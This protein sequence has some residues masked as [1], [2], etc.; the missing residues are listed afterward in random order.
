MSHIPANRFKK[1]LHGKSISIYT[2]NNNNGVSLQVTNYGARIVS[3]YVPDRNGVPQDIVLGYDCIEDYLKTKNS[4][5]GATVGR[6]ANRIAN[7][8]FTLNN[9]IY[10]LNANDTTHCLHGGAGGFHN[11]VWD[12]HQISDTALELTY[13]SP[14]GEE[15]FPGT[16]SVKV[17]YSI[18][19]NSEVSIT[20]FATTDKTTVVNLTHHSYFNLQDAGKTSIEDHQLEI[21]ASNYTPVN[22]SL[23]PRGPIETVSDTP[24]DFRIATK[25]GKRI[26][27][28]NEQL[29]IG[30]GYD[31]NYVLYGKDLRK[32]ATVKEP[33]SGRVMEIVTTEP[34]I[35]FYSGNLIH[36]DILGKNKTLYGNRHG[37]CLETQGFP[38]S[39]NQSDFPST[40]L[41][42][43]DTYRSTTIYTFTTVP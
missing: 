31:H 13:V 18:G 7:S 35:Q 1:T 32:A 33:I 21:D 17:I 27:Q 3:L 4:Y 36:S 11:V 26:D 23:I 28:P 41:T 29:K 16:L 25:I 42:P 30:S 9:K 34:C 20:Y 15:G 19:D 38:D 43:E 10:T 37:F 6:F 12:A 22:R 14:D 8:Q 5:F 39:P 24:F 40:I 2:L